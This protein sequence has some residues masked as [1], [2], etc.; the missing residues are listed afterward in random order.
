MSVKIIRLQSENIKR[1][2]AIDITPEGNLITIG[3]KN[4]AGKSSA[5]DSI[6]YALGGEKLVPSQPIRK[7]QT[8][9]KIVVE[10][11][12]LI[13]TRRFK[14]AEIYP[15]DCEQ[16]ALQLDKKK[17]ASNC[18]IQTKGPA[19]GPPSSSLVV[20]TKDGAKYAKPQAVLDKLLGALTFD[21]LAFTTAKPEEQDRVLRRLVK[22][23]VTP[24]EEARKSAVERRSMHKKSLALAEMRVEGMQQFDKVL[25]EE[26]S[27]DAVSQEMLKAEEY[28]K[29]ADDAERLV[30]KIAD[31]VKDNELAISNNN[32]D[33][34]RLEERLYQLRETEN[35]LHVTDAEY[36]SSL[37]AAQI[38]AQAARAVVPD[39]SEIRRKLSDTEETNRKVRANQQYA[40]ASDTVSKLRASVASEDALVK[41]ADADKDAALRAVQ[42][43]V[44]GLGLSDEGVLWEGLPLSEVSSSVKLRVS[45]A[46]SIALNPTLKVLLIR[47]GNLLDHDSLK[48]VAEQADAAGAQVWIEYV[49]ADA[50]GVSVMLEDGHVA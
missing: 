49:T 42:F 26:L 1:I 32:I 48:L 10:L 39:M 21:A 37:D 24:F 15:C 27:M 17:H 31:K 25:A 16:G 2:S 46:V 34:L 7:G 19:F 36:R 4:D 20:S 35:Q 6:A 40:L 11:D 47:N 38:T 8:E 18:L 45:V 41:Q 13:V 23:D 3:G 5:L 9:A 12:D 43:P 44:E 50:E 29:L 14:R 30:S 28:R 22:L 33:I